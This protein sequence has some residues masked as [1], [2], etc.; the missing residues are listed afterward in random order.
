MRPI[1][2]VIEELQKMP[3]DAVCYAYQ[4]ESD[5]IVIWSSSGDY[6]GS[7]DAPAPEPET[8][9]QVMERMPKAEDHTPHPGHFSG[10]IDYSK[11]WRKMMAWQ[12]DLKEAQ[13]RSE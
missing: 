12:K 11:F 6:L 2:T 13:E 1:R 3:E 9:D 4:G 10:P 7:I 5:C 8:V